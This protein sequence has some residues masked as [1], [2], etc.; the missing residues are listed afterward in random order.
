MKLLPT[1]NFLGKTVTKMIVGDNPQT[2]HSYIVDRITGEE[3]TAFYT[4]EK[5]LETLFVIQDAGY[6]TI[7]PLSTPQNLQILK[8]FRK[9]GGKLQI[10]FQP[11]TAMPLAENLPLMLELEPIGIYHQG[12]KTDFYN[13][14][15]DMKTFF[16]NLE[17]LKS[18]GVKI[19][20]GTHVPE[21]VL[22]AERENWGVDFYT[23]CMYNARR[24]RHGEDSGFIT[25]KT[26]AG[27]IFN[28]NDRFES[29]KVVQKVQKPFIAYKIFAGGQVFSGHA[30]EEYPAVAEAFIKE[31]YENIKPGDVACVGVFQRDTDQAR[32]NA[33]IVRRVLA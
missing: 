5:I 30:P 10:I 8:Q 22:K 29:Y 11:Y 6:N 21:T 14:T 24:N 33:E 20:L 27:L 1:V 7:M 23:M 18:S 9:E 25:G 17:L 28:A 2:G 32:G 31:T 16:S 19:G 15:G 26:K 3:M 12:T 4:P 13:E